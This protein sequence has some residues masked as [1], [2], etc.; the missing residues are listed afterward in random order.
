[1]EIT[2][3]VVSE[4]QGFWA[5]YIACSVPVFPVGG[6]AAGD[7]LDVLVCSPY[8]SGQYLISQF[9]VSKARMELFEAS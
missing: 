3:H 4:N 8:I 2:A 7:R 9:S 1:M 5:M 6:A